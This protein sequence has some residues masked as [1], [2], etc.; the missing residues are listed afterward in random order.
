M[1][2][3]MPPHPDAT[4]LP[5]CIPPSVAKHS[6]TAERFD[7]AVGCGSTVD[8]CVELMLSVVAAC[9][10]LLLA[11][12]EVCVEL[13]F[14]TVE[15]FVG[16]LVDVD[17]GTGSNVGALVEYDARETAVRDN[18]TIVDMQNDVGLYD[19]SQEAELV[20][21][22]IYSISMLA[23]VTISGVPKVMLLIPDP[24]VA[25]SL[26]WAIGSTCSLNDATSVELAGPNGP[27]GV[28][29]V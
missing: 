16:M 8:V 13:V 2:C 5:A 14:V 1:C 21:Q 23:C 10:E 6:W 25:S 9:A 26:D 28:M 7:I 19:P 27:G 18:G 24:Y 29:V 17:T 15:V 4:L 11:V 20:A 12:V 3:S 22:L